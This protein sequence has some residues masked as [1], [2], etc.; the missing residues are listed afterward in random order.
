MREMIIKFGGFKAT[1]KMVPSVK[2]R[3]VIT[4]SLSD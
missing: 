3:V 1:Y 2:L 4:E